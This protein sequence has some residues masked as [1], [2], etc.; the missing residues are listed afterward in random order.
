IVWAHMLVGLHYWLRLRRGYRQA[1]GVLYPLA[2]LVPLLAILGFARIGAE[3]QAAGQPAADYYS[4]DYPL[5][6]TEQPATFSLGD[7]GLLVTLGLIGATLSARQIRAV[8]KRKGNSYRLHHANG[9]TLVALQGRSILEALR[10]GRIAHASVCGGRARCTTCRVR[11]SEGLEL[12][13]PPNDLERAALL[14]IAAAPNVRLA[15]QT[16]PLRD[17]QIAPL[18]AADTLPGDRRKGG[19]QGRERS[20]T[21]LF[22]DLRGSTR[23]GETKLPYDVLFILNQFFAE[24]ASALQ[25]T[26]GHYAQ[27]NGDGLLALYGLRGGSKRACLAALSGAVTMH[28]HLQKLNNT[29][30]GELEQPLRIGIGIHYGSAIVGSMGPP[31]SPIVSAIGDTIN[32]AARLEALTKDYACTLVASADAVQRAGIDATRFALHSVQVRGKQEIV[33]VYAIDDIDALA[34]LLEPSPLAQRKRGTE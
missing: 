31:E 10:M 2:L 7:I 14:R 9:Q 8:V 21:A 3:L 6:Y 11:V 32:L 18:L 33:E 12:L 29:L 22:V 19:M 23:L 26:D 13:P 16:R 20:V 27:F 1:L 24:M 4:M 30:A 34:K 17:L 28:R 15:C 5:A 25:K